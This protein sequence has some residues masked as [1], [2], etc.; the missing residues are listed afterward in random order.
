MNINW[1]SSATTKYKVSPINHFNTGSLV[2]FVGVSRGGFL[3][4]EEIKDEAKAY[5]T[6]L[7][8]KHFNKTTLCAIFREGCN[9]VVSHVSSSASAVQIR[10]KSINVSV[11][12]A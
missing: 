11:T 3:T 1:N 9:P 8:I 6:A 2:Q 12:E 4:E 7:I 10:L 5:T